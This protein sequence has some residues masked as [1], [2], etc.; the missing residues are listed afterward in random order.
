MRCKLMSSDRVPEMLLY[1]QVY[2]A[3]IDG[4]TEVAVKVFHESHNEAQQNDILREVAIIKSC[5]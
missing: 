3:T 1:E 4:V 2:K 5:R